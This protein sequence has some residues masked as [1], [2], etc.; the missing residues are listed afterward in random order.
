MQVRTLDLTRDRAA[1]LAFLA[2]SAAAGAYGLSE[3]KRALIELADGR[4]GTGVVAESMGEIQGYGAL[5]P[6][7]EPGEWAMELV[8]DGLTAGEVADLVQ[9]A[10]SAAVESGASRLRWWVYDAGRDSLPPRFGFQ[11]ERELLFLARDLP[12]GPAPEWGE[13]IRVTGFRVGTD[14]EAW[15]A[16][17]N[18]AFAGH[19]ENGDLTIQ[20]VERRMAMDWFEPEGLRMAWRDAEL[21]G[22][23]WTKF[24]PDREG[25]IYIIGVAPA[26]QGEGLG[27][28]LVLEGMRHLAEAGCRRV[29]L[30]TEGDN[31]KAI[32]LY[33]ALGM[34]TERVHRSF[35]R[36]VG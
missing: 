29:F 35:I 21:A 12:V 36:S 10:V 5:A 3:N 7:S 23:C 15:L 2:E 20:D 13:G 19:P 25:E 11:P 22:F 6:A 33:E 18:G 4:P 16:V 9:A 31:L 30:Y 28:A 34:T 26:F 27:K 32:S 17:N 14:E 24:H 8:V 1:V